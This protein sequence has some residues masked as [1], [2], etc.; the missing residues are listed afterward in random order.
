M[1]MPY[2]ETLARHSRIRYQFTLH[3]D[4][5]SLF[6]IK[7]RFPFPLSSSSLS[8]AF[9]SLPTHSVSR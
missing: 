9:I 8:L 6:D 7:I 1:S 2:R 4:Q 3:R 5:V